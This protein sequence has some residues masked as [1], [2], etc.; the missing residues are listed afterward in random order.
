MQVEGLRKLEQESATY[1]N[2]LRTIERNER[3]QQRSKEYKYKSTTNKM[4][5]EE[6]GEDMIVSEDC[7]GIESEKTSSGSVYLNSS[8]T[9]AEQDQ[10]QHHQQQHHSKQRRRTIRKQIERIE[11]YLRET[12][13]LLHLTTSNSNSTNTNST[14][15]STANTEMLENDTNSGGVVLE[16]PVVAGREMNPKTRGGWGFWKS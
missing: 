4:N 7:I 13:K 16:A 3:R 2:Q 11:A 8:S 1:M 9:G 6:K 5:Q 12:E 10:Q 15:T 14:T